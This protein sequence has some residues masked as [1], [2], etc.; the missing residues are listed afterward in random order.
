MGA[1]PDLT[2]YHE[3]VQH[4]PRAFADPGLK[5]VALELDRFGMPKPATGGNA[6]VYKAKEPGGFLSFK[7]TWAIRC[8]LRPIS[9]HAERYEA[10]SKHLRKVR[11]PYD[12]DF[13]F[14]KQGI[15]I[16]SSW[17]PIVKMQW[18]DGDLLH[19]HIEKHLRNPASLE[20][21]RAKWVTLVRHLEAAQVAH[22]DLQHGNILVRGG[23]IQLVDYDGMWVP[24]L[25]GRKATELGHR[26]YQHPERSEQDYGQ[27]IDRFSALVIYLSLAALER[28]ATLWE[29]FHTGD[30]LI[31]V[32]EDFHQLGR[33]AIWQQLRRIGSRQI[34]Q[35]AT[36]V[37]AMVQQHPM[38]VSNLD[39]VLKNL[40]SFKFPTSIPAS[41]PAPKPAAVQG[42]RAAGAMPSWMKKT[43]YRD[44]S[45][46]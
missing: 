40:A 36:A 19:S 39:S 9:D 20:A 2:E 4:P 3:A 12:V 23:S 13:Q 24:A 29:R 43:G 35:L 42:A 5:V 6:V 44:H 11:L 1:W 26:A 46:D 8:F 41:P 22:G 14:L 37:A 7:K 32:R 25:R 38:K 33:S 17:F 28:D 21:L 27:E 31:F 18:A 45:D 30:N 16:R 15:Q 10:I 34:D